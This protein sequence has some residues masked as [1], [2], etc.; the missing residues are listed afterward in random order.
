MAGRFDWLS[1]LAWHLLAD[2][3]PPA[4]PRRGR[5]M[6]QTPLRKVVTLW[7]S[8]LITGCCWGDLPHGPHGH[9]K[10]RRLGGCSIGKPL[11]R[12]ARG[13]CADGEPS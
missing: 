9:L 12:V 11:A 10:V 8:V 2:M 6:P 5:G 4:P 7:L 3:F 1:D 13:S